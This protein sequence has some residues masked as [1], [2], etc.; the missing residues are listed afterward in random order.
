MKG[1]FIVGR[2]VV[3]TL[4]IRDEVSD[5]RLSLNGTMHAWAKVLKELFGVI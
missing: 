3:W 2:G 4:S 5:G 1:G